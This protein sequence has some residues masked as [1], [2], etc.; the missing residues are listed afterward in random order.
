M[1]WQLCHIFFHL[2]EQKNIIKDFVIIATKNIHSTFAIHITSKI[3][4]FMNKLE[5]SKNKS[6][7]Q[8]RTL[9]R[10]SPGGTHE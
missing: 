1:I 8:G 7:F 6:K 9:R 2:K 10:E 4:I 5:I 3:N